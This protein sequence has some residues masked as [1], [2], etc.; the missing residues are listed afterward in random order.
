MNI[1]LL[2]N[3]TCI[4]VETSGKTNQSTDTSEK[5]PKNNINIAKTSIT[6]LLILRGV[7][8]YFLKTDQL[9][10]F[11]YTLGLLFNVFDMSRFLNAKNRVVIIVMYIIFLQKQN[12]TILTRRYGVFNAGN[13]N[14]IIVIIYSNEQYDIMILI[15]QYIY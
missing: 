2:E 12:V 7:I 9:F 11:D 10:W 13:Y 8:Y 5:R 14:I 6:V 3:N 1:I 4:R 15:T